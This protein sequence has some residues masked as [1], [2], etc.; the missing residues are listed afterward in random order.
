[1]KPP[2]T[3]QISRDEV[4]VTLYCPELSIYTC[5]KTEQEAKRK[6]IDAIVEYWQFL[7]VQDFKDESPYKEHLELLT[8]KVLPALADASLRSPHRPPSLIDELLE[9]LS[10]EEREASWDADIFGSLVKSSAP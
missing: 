5:G 8:D 1:M 2:L 3:A 10:R 4:G 6:F 7:Q 9:L